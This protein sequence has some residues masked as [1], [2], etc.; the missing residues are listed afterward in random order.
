MSYERLRERFERISALGEAAGVLGWDMQTV[1][2]PGGADARARQLATLETLRHELLVDERVA[3]WLDEA[4]GALDDLSDWDRA[5]VLEMRRTWAHA[6][7][8][9]PR[10]VEARSRAGSA[11]FHAWQAA[12]P[13]NDW[14]SFRPHLETV[15]ALTREVAEAKASVLGCSPYDAMI[16][17]FE[18]G[19]GAE[20]IARIFEPLRAGIP[21]L[22]DAVIAKQA[23]E[24]PMLPL[25]GS[26]DVRSQERLARRLM[27]A[28]GFDFSHG[29]LDVSAHPFCGGVP[30]DV[31]ITTRYREDDFASAIMGVLHETG[32]ALYERQLPAEW[33]GQPVGN[34]RGMAMHESQSLLIEMQACR[35]PGFLKFAAPIMREQLGGEGPAWSADNLRRHYTSVERGLIRV[36]ADEV[37]YPLHVILRFDIEQSIFN[38]DLEI[39]DLP[40]AWSNGMEAML[41]VRPD[42]DANGCMQ[43]VHWTDGAFGYFPSYTLGAIAA[44]QLFAAATA[45]RPEI[46]EDIAKGDFGALRTW[47]GEHVHGRASS[48]T[49]AE[50]LADATGRSFDPSALL[51]HLRTRYLDA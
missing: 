19:I 5:N 36:D 30:E 42:S 10:L 21:A 39:A 28:V 47:L 23:S 32:H 4:E 31:R 34:A 41:G 16:D 40:D 6:A 46:P 44:A 15:V 17:A 7:A 37:S 1:M 33:R 50:I 45:A 35:S 51:N 49:S 43:D 11:C 26:F 22:L 25:D 24:A 14:K 13:A 8:V 18:P 20:E 9:E 12:R 48:A 27:E 29:R 38:G 2:P 3:A